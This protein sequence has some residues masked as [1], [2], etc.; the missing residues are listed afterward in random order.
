MAEHADGGA[1]EGAGED[2]PLVPREETIERVEAILQPLPPVERQE[3]IEQVMF[4]QGPLPPAELLRQY[5]EVVP[6]LARE[7]ADGAGDERR[8]RH[9]MTEKTGTQEFALNLAGLAAMLIALVMM[10]SI[11]AYMVSKDQAAAGAAL[12]GAIIVGVIV[13]LSN[14]RKTEATKPVVAAQTTDKPKAED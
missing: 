14:Y 2:H 1:E 3:V 8:F 12:G 7:I 13:A 4:H 5:D 10:L 11:V 9:R 6:G